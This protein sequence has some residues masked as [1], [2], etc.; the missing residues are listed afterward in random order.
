MT[1]TPLQA[2]DFGTPLTVLHAQSH[3]KT[4]WRVL[5]GLALMVS[6]ASPALANDPPPAAASKATTAPSQQ[7]NQHA[8]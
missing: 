8:S 4:A 3:G 5:S 2:P 1:L 6:L 7:P